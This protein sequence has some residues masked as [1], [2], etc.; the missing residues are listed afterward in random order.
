[1]NTLV[2]RGTL[3]LIWERHRLQVVRAH[4]RLY[5]DRTN[6]EQRTAKSLE[7]HVLRLGKRDEGDLRFVG[8]AQIGNFTDIAAL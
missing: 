2:M 3:G 7:K 4:F 8:A 5:I 1:M 6:I